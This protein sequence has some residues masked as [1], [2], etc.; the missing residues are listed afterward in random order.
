MRYSTLREFNNPMN[1][2]KSLCRCAKRAPMTFDQ[3]EQ[4]VETFLGCQIGIELIVRLVGSFKACENL[5]DA[6]HDQKFTRGTTGSPGGASSHK[7]WQAHRVESPNGAP[8]ASSPGSVRYLEAWL[9]YQVSAARRNERE[10]GVCC[11][12]LLSRLRLVLG[13][14]PLNNVAKAYGNACQFGAV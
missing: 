14:E 10:G 2:L 6:I 13:G 5:G 7:R 1:S 12:P 3:L 4:Q 8:A 9:T 11:K